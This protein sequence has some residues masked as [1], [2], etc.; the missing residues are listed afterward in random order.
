MF[1]DVYSTFWVSCSAKGKGI[2]PVVASGKA[3]LEFLVGVTHL[4]KSLQ[5]SGIGSLD[6]QRIC[7]RMFQRILGQTGMI[8]YLCGKK[9]TLVNFSE[10]I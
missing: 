1:T 9:Q 7:Q 2:C 4:L 5:D 6:G 3:S 8:Y 10:I